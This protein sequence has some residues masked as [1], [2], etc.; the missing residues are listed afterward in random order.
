MSY[1]VKTL[2]TG[3][4]ATTGTVIP[5]VLGA[6]DLWDGIWA[7]APHHG[8]TDRYLKNHG[9]MTNL[10]PWETWAV[11]Q[12]DLSTND[13]HITLTSGQWMVAQGTGQSGDFTFLV[14]LDVRAG[15]RD[16][17]RFPGGFASNDSGKW[18]LWNGAV[19]TGTGVDA[20]G[21]AVYVFVRRGGTWEIWRNGVKAWSAALAAST[22]QNIGVW[23][24]YTSAP[25]QDFY[26]ARYAARALTDAQI[27]AASADARALHGI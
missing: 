23:P 9:D 15:S 17:V 11:A 8:Q 20:L 2:P 14:V 22:D 1:A 3:D 27:V 4:T 6:V 24:R 12:P 7:A 26:Q 10:K 18:I 13:P 5:P 19:N 16:T 21:K 25:D